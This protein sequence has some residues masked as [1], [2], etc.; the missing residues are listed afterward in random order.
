M[1]CDKASKPKGSIARTF[2]DGL[3]AEFLSAD[4]VRVASQVAVGAC[5]QPM[6]H[7]IRFHSASRADVLQRIAAGPSSTPN[8]VRYC[9]LQNR[10]L[11][12]LSIRKNLLMDLLCG[13][14]ER[15]LVAPKPAVGLMG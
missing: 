5:P 2:G 3:A 14:E 4:D 12:D 1:A 9:C 10:S 8:V 13:S 7:G 15:R 6:D 11:F